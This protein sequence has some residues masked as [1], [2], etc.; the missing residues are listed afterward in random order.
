MDPKIIFEDGYL[1]II[2]KPSGTV[3]NRADSVKGETVQDWADKKLGLDMPINKAVSDKNCAVQD[4]AEKKLQIANCELRIDSKEDIDNLVNTF[5]S[6]SGIVHRLDK[7]TSADYGS[8][9]KTFLSRSGIIHRLDKETSGLLVIAKDPQTFILMQGLFK[10][11]A[12]EKRYETLVH[13]QMQAAAGE[14]N[15]SVGR[16][17]WNREKFGV[18]PGGK[19]AQTAWKLDFLYGTDGGG[20]FSLLTV[21]PHT[22]RTHQIRIHF[23]YI[24]HSVVGDSLYAGRKVY[25]QDRKFCPRLF[26]HAKYLK[27]IHPVTNKVLE[28][29][30]KLPGDLQNVLE[31]LSKIDI[32]KHSEEN[33][34]F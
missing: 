19:E 16:L 22:G 33:K 4:W 24:G 17:P 14:I 18:L 29:E 6:R 5:L 12:V 15:A 21:F 28:A 3:V 2:E 10:D 20:R 7:E 1:L 13:G 23:K 25:R 32:P 31:T 11:R 26:L 30:S 9:V 8:L 27:F 34:G